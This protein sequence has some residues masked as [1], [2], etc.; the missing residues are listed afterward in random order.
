MGSLTVFASPR[1]MQT[2]RR[3][4]CR[5]RFAAVEGGFVPCIHI[6]RQILVGGVRYNCGSHIAAICFQRYDWGEKQGAIANARLHLAFTKKA[7]FCS[8]PLRERS[9]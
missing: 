4:W 9:T 7:Q 2:L 8:M 6:Y 1:L 3:S 5:R